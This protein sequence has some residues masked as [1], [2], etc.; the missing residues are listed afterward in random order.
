MKELLKTL[1]RRFF[2]MGTL[3]RPIIPFKVNLLYVGNSFKKEGVSYYNVGDYLSKVVFEMLM[4]HFGIKSYWTRKTHCVAHIGSIIQFI[5][6]N[7]IIYGS[8]FLF[9]WAMP[10]F[11]RK[12]LKLDIRAV[13]GPLTRNVLLELGYNVPPVYGDPAILLPLFY[14]LNSQKP[15]NKKYKFTVI[16]HE[17]HIHLYK[18]VPYN[19]LSTLTNDW[20]HFIQE[21]WQ[22]ELI[23]SSSLH[24]IIIA[25]AYGIPAIFLDETENADQLKYDDYYYSTGRKQYIKAKSVEECLKLTPEKLP[26]FKQM[27]QGLLEAFPVDIFN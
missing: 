22:S 17:S 27:Q 6:Q 15:L 26:D 2:I 9:H 20:E 16:P 18:N 10:Q 12:K 7:C 23:I 14:P 8:G 5:G 11:A 25:E 13:R 19:V 4:K 3:S 1:F 24:G 21:I